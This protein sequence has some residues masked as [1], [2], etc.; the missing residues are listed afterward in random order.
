MAGRV[1]DPGGLVPLVRA[2]LA[3][4]V[5]AATIDT[6]AAALAEA[7]PMVEVAAILGVKDSAVRGYV[8]SGQLRTYGDNRGNTYCLRSEVEAVRGKVG[9]SGREAKR[10][11]RDRNIRRLAKV[12]GMT[13]E[14]IAQ[15]NGVTAGT[16]FRVLAAGK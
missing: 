5:D 10:A 15:L 7:V 16:V 14:R 12:P 1:A 8:K 11:A 6:V 9:Q 2:L 4:R 13:R 3:G